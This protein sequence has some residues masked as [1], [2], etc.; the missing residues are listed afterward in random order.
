M[1]TK[2]MITLACGKY[3]RTDA[4]REDRIPVEG[5]DINYLA[6]PPH[7]IFWRMLKYN[8]FDVCEISLS[9]YLISREQGFSKLMAIP[10][11]PSRVFRHGNIFVNDL[12]L[13]HI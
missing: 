7:E 13:I 4:I 8:E 3:D 9:S 10:V 2:P 5:A 11:F 6:L 12:S 1:M